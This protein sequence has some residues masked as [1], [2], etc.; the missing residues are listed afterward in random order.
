MKRYVRA[1]GSRSFKRTIK[2]G[3]ENAGCSDVKIGKLESDHCKIQL[4]LPNGNST[5]TTVWFNRSKI[6]V[7]EPK[8]VKTLVS[9]S[10]IPETWTF[11]SDGNVL[12]E[13]R[14][15]VGVVETV[16]LNDTTYKQKT[17]SDYDKNSIRTDSGDVI[18][19]HPEKAKTYTD[20]VKSLE[21]RKITHRS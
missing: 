10:K 1:S 21:T 16:K 12:D 3:F 15:I 13:T 4:T 19:D 6:N 18:I 14:N 5:T 11:D 8:P 17:R 20:V 7:G 2:K 9:I